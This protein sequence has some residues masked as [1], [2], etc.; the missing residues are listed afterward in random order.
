M[1]RIA[2]LKNIVV[3]EIY[4][5]T[6]FTQAV[7]EV[8]KNQMSLHLKEHH[9]SGTPA[10]TNT[11]EVHGPTISNERIEELKNLVLND[12]NFG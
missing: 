10:N 7:M 5:N 1:E 6:R 3:N 9:N 12:P 4:S 8:Y 2:E 11:I